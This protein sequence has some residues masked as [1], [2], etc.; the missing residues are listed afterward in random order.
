MKKC[1]V[2]FLFLMIFRPVS[3]QPISTITR[4]ILRIDSAYQKKPA[5]RTE[6][7]LKP[8]VLQSRLLNDIKSEFWAWFYMAKDIEVTPETNSYRLHCYEQA[9]KLIKK[10]GDVQTELDVIRKMADIHIQQQYFVTAENELLGIIKNK[11]ASHQNLIFATDL[12]SALYSFT[13]N[14]DKALYY[15]LT[16]VK[17]MRTEDMPYALTFYDRLA[18]IYIDLDNPHESYKWSKKAYEAAIKIK[19]RSLMSIVRTTVIINLIDMGKANA[20]L[21]LVK[22]DHKKYPPSDLSTLRDLLSQYARCYDAL[23][24]KK[25]AEAKLLLMIDLVRRNKN[26]FSI[27]EKAV[28]FHQTGNYYLQNGKP[29]VA[30]SFFLEALSGYKLAGY[31]NDKKNIFML[32]YKADSSMQNFGTAITWLQQNTRIKD[33]IFNAR[34]NKQIEELQIAYNTE[35]KDKNINDLKNAAKVQKLNLK[36]AEQTRNWIIGGSLMLLVIAALLYRQAK[37][38][39][40]TNGLIS[41]KNGML[42]QLVIE[43]E[44][45]LKEVHHRVKNN[46]HTV[47]CLLESQAKYLANDALK[48]IENS[49]NRIY[50]MSL[51]HQKLYRSE[52]IK[53]IHMDEYIPE[54]VANLRTSFGINGLIGFVFN[55]DPITLSITYAIPIGLIINEAVTNSI[56]YA[57][58][59]AKKGKI[60]ISLIRENH[61]LQL[62]IADNGTGLLENPMDKQYQSLGIELMKG[63][64]A[65]INGDIKFDSDPGLQITIIFKPSDPV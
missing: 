51:I 23:N 46:L 55:L 27:Q 53:T 8:L 63:L 64:V 29:A 11:Q 56:K 59:E 40:K 14:Y 61:Q 49:Q 1:I 45:L 6:P 17:S 54:L 42:E 15:G 57:F 26:K 50:A 20:A 35:Q 30:K 41:R 28:S 39:R 33:S 24:Q 7:L 22:K 5:L 18:V 34:K 12:L 36:Q 32:L 16:T 13:G 58:P 38:T 44:W 19:D 65:E 9:L 52:N 37:V 2:F 47:I 10:T 4:Q 60:T 62:I 21:D 43:K 31:E 25:I 48:A 3:A